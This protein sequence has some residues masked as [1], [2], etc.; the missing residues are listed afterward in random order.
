MIS[1]Q[2]YAK[3]TIMAT[4]KPQIGMKGMRRAHQQDPSQS[5]AELAG[6][7]PALIPQAHGGALYAGGVAGHVGGSGRPSSALRER[8]RGS[9]QERVKVLEE[10]ADDAQAD[11]QDRIRALDV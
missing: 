6:E 7:L 11:P 5:A 1:N 8:L 3:G 2:R 4:R 9:F 10:I